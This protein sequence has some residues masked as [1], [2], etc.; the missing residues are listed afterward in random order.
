MRDSLSSAFSYLFMATIFVSA[1]SLFAVIIFMRSFTMEIGGME[2]Q[3]GYAFL[4]V[5]II[6]IIVAPIFHYI[7][8]KLE[9]NTKGMDEI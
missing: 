1:I 3:A 9:K 4:Y 2:K 8:N 7:S 6:C 5:F